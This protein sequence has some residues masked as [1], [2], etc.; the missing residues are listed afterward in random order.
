MALVSAERQREILDYLSVKKSA[1]VQRLCEKLF[2]SPATIRRDLAAL[3]QRGLIR[4]TH[5]GAALCEGANDEVSLFARQSV[6]SRQKGEI[7]KLASCFVKDSHCIFMDSSSTVCGVAPHLARYR[8]LSV[9][10]NGLHCALALAKQAQSGGASGCSVYFPAGR[11][12]PRSNSVTGPDTLESLA[13]FCADAALVSCGGLSP[14]EGAT[15]PSLEQS[16]VKLQMLTHAKTRLL[17]CDSSKFGRVFFSRTCAVSL[18]DYVITD[19]YPGE[20]WERVVSDAGC[21][22][23]YPEF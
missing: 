12:A 13:R 21:E 1:S 16:R 10:T 4:R 23:V 14:E 3:E 5:G 9:V 20:M 22:L 6:N 11:L 17:L 2:A 19:R 8:N 18:F 15:E 7:A